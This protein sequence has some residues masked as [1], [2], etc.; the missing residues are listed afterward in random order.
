M[1]QSNEDIDRLDSLLSQI[2]QLSRR[3][4]PDHTLTFGQFAVLRMLFQNG[5]MSMGSIAT[6]LAMSL[7][8][9]TGIVDRLFNQG[10]VKRTRLRDDRRVVWVNLSETGYEQ[11]QRLQDERHQQMCNVLKPLEADELDLLLRLL[12]RIAGRIEQEELI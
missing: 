12:E 3:R 10:L 1:H 11:M 5:P 9:A 8:G 6:T 2:G 7:A 4:K